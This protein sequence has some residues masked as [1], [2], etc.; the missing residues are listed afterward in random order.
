MTA[1]K[2]ILIM[3]AGT[4]GHIFPGLAIARELVARGWAIHWMGTPAGMENT[5]VREAGYPMVTVAM[6]GVRGKG[7][8]A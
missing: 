3:A 5:L 4:G 6:K 8:L 1:R 7:M 2:T